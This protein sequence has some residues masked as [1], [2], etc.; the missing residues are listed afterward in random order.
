ML[1]DSHNF[2]SIYNPRNQL[3]NQMVVAEMFLKFN[4]V[5]NRINQLSNQYEDDSLSDE[6]D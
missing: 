1:E 2:S 6:D 4:T 5:S 3:A